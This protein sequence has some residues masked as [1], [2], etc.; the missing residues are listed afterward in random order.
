MSRSA[1]TGSESSCSRATVLHHPTNPTSENSEPGYDLP[2]FPF[3]SSTFGLRYSLVFATDL[4]REEMPHCGVLTIPTTSFPS[5][6]IDVINAF[7]C[8]D[9]YAEQMKAIDHAL[10]SGNQ[11]L[12]CSSCT[13]QRD[14]GIPVAGRCYSRTACIRR[15][16]PF[17]LYTRSMAREGVYEYHAMI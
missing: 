3:P 5:N 12:P 11:I 2:K 15:E 9:W 6:A 1:Y 17:R 14:F 4:S 7:P 8:Y 10:I 13:C 16:R